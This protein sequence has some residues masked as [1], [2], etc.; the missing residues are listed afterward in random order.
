MV[1]SMAGWWVNCELRVILRLV[2]SHVIYENMLAWV[3]LVLTRVKTGRVRVEFFQPVRVAGQ[4]SVGIFF[5][6]LNSNPTRT[7]PVDTICHP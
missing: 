6:T 4:V 1:V 7:R 5:A 3:G 2:V